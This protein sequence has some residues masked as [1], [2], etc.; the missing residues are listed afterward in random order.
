[1]L[2]RKIATSWLSPSELR[3]SSRAAI[4]ITSLEATEGRL[5]ADQAPGTP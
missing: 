2:D 1:M 3:A 5:L 4:C